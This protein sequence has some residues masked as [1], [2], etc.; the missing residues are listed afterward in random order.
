MLRYLSIEA[1][2]SPILFVWRWRKPATKEIAQRAADVSAILTAHS[3]AAGPETAFNGREAAPDFPGHRSRRVGDAIYAYGLRDLRSRQPAMASTIE[4]YA[5]IG[6]TQTAALVGDDGSID[7]LCAPRFDSDACFA[8][9]LGDEKHGRWQ[10]A[11]GGR[12]PRHVPAIP[13]WHA[14]TRD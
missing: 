13:R 1:G 11:A 10:I 7:W 9:L 6:D 2:R 3:G 5:M 4:Q 12:W 8:A 14:R